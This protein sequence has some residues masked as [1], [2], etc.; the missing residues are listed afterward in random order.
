[1]PFIRHM[2]SHK[3]TVWPR[4]QLTRDVPVVDELMTIPL[5]GSTMDATVPCSSQRP[6]GRSHLRGEQ[7]RLFP[8]GKVAAFV[9]LVEVDELGM[10]LLGPASAGEAA[11]KT[12]R[13]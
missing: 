4:A 9:D 5:L 7:L 12:P 13:R 6:E 1:M 10:G 11:P 3:F 8:R 2:R